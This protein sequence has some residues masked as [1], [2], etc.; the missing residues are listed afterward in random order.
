MTVSKEQKGSSWLQ[1]LI[2]TFV[3]IGL[4]VWLISMMDWKQALQVIKEGSPLYLVSSFYRH[5]NNSVYKYMEVEAV[6]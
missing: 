2:R 6:N 3:S 1:I 5:P 4:M